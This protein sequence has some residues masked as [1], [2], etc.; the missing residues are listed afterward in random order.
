MRKPDFNWTEI[1]KVNPESVSEFSNAE[2]VLESNWKTL[3]LVKGIS[4][5][6]VGTKDG[7][8]YIMIFIKQGKGDAL[9]DL[10]PDRLD[11]YDVFYYE[12]TPSY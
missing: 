1:S 8:P 4:G 9:K 6:A 11:R 7:K 10:I 12:V 5:S 2:K 3:R